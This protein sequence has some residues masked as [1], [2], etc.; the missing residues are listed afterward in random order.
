[1]TGFVDPTA[2][3]NVVLDAFHARI[4]EGTAW[5]WSHRYDAVANGAVVTTVLQVFGVAHLVGRVDG[6]GAAQV[7]F[8]N[9]SSFTDGTSIAPTN[10]NGFKSHVAS[11]IVHHTAS[12]NVDGDN[13]VETIIG[14]AGAVAA[15]AGGGDS[16]DFAEFLLPEGTYA[17]RLTNVSG[18]AADFA[19]NLEWYNPGNVG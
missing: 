4:H 19:V 10:R 16:G 12:L 14:G 8:L 2:N 15:R 9:V 7:D 1:M 3:A 18:G 17:V 13:I 11:M 5:H 6:G